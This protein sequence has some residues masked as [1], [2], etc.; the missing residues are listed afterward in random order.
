LNLVKIRKIKTMSISTAT[1]HDPHS[2]RTLAEITLLGKP[3]GTGPL[4][5]HHGSLQTFVVRSGR[6]NLWLVWTR[7]QSV[8]LRKHSSM[9]PANTQQRIRL[10][11]FPMYEEGQAVLRLSDPEEKE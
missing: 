5:R 8:L 7:R 9:N 1:L 6:E 2:G 4:M 3:V 11:T 10:V